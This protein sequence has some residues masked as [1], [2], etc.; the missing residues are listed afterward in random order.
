MVMVMVCAG[1]SVVTHGPSAGDADSGGA[2]VWQPGVRGIFSVFSTQFCCEFTM[3]QKM[4][5]NV[6]EK[7][8]EDHRAHEKMLGIT[9]HQRNAQQNHSAVSPCTCPSGHHQTGSNKVLRM[10]REGSPCV[11]LVGTQ[12]GAA[13]MENSMEYP[14]KFN[15]QPAHNPTVHSWVLSKEMKH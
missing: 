15:M 14:H 5:I 12:T 4:Y 11:L 10:Q 13:I 8:A 2:G 1:S 3:A 9:N 7:W 6:V